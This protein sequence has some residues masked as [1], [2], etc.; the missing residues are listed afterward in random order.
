MRGTTRRVVVES[1]GGM[2][3]EMFRFWIDRKYDD[4][5]REDFQVCKENVLKILDQNG[6]NRPELYSITMDN[7]KREEIIARRQEKQ[8]ST[9]DED[10]QAVDEYL[11]SVFDELLRIKNNAASLRVVDR[12]CEYNGW[13]GASAMSK[14]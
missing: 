11:E 1:I 14:L 9:K 6:S 13:S 4:N 8:L 12:V 5:N 3:E 2:I 7:I 10:K